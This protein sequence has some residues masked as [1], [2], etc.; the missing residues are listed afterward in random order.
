MGKLIYSAITSLDGYVSDARGKWDWA[1]PTAEVHAAVNDL[2]RPIGTH[3]LGRRMYEVLAVWDS[4]AMHE[5]E[6]AEIRDYAAL[7]QAT[8]KIVY[9]TTL[10]S[11]SADKTQL[12]RAFD[13]AAVRALKAASARDVSIGGPGIAAEALRAGLVD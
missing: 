10:E 13:P 4:P 2:Q 5:H 9:S 8:D 6:A 11:V 3:L 1:F 7:W 12:K